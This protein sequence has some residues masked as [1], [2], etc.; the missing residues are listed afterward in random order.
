MEVVCHCPL[1][2]HDTWRTDNY[3]MK[4][5]NFRPNWKDGKKG[6]DCCLGAKSQNMLCLSIVKWFRKGFL[7]LVASNS[8]KQLPKSLPSRLKLFD[9]P[10]H[11]K[12]IWYSCPSGGCWTRKRSPNVSRKCICVSKSGVGIT[13]RSTCAIQRV[14]RM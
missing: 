14:S 3:L 1:L 4:Q 6:Y 9:I 13:F 10:V 7:N 11:L 5:C 12:L 2:R 8:A